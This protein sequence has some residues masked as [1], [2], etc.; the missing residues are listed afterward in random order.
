MEKQEGQ[1]LLA[2]FVLLDLKAFSLLLFKVHDLILSKY[3]KEYPPPHC[4]LQS[5]ARVPINGN[6]NVQL[7]F[8]KIR[9]F[10]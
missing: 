1:L 6:D 5:S 3:L 8:L 10:N 4:T 7:L 2:A 9:S